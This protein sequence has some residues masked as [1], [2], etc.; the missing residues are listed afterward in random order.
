M[1]Q[2]I[3]NIVANICENKN[4]GMLTI[5]FASEKNLFKIYFKNG[6]IYHLS[7]GFKKG[8]ECLNEI[9]EREPISYNFIPDVTI[10][11]SSGNL[12]TEKIVENLNK[13]NKYISSEEGATIKSSDFE[14]VKEAIKTALIRQIG[15]IGGKIL[16]KYIREKWVPVNPPTK[17]DFLKLA[18]LLMEE[19]EEPLSRKEFFNEINKILEVHK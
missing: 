4:T 16:E 14:K 8:L 2:N 6:E 11:I 13:I 15:P 1:K 18:N 19:I 10:D 9:N 7:F 12:S 5:T 17:E 3:A